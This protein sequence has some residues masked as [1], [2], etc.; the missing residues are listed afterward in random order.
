MT[1]VLVDTASWIC[2]LGGGFFSLVG[3]LGLLRL[4]DF[5]SRLHA[6]GITDTLG[7][8]LI[9]LGLALHAGL[10]IATIKLAFIFLFLFLTSP[11]ACHALAKA[12]LHGG[13]QPL[14]D[15]SDETSLEE[16][17]STS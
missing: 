7:A 5:F 10:T 11:A 13:L 12:A 8:W 2:L 14:T 4:P 9:L 3:G 15:K 6:G 17:S 1:N 16:S